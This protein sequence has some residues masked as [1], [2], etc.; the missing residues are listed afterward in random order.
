MATFN[1]RSFDNLWTDLT[2]SV[3]LDIE[4]ED[5]KKIFRNQL[6]HSTRLLADTVN[7]FSLQ[8]EARG[9]L[10]E[11]MIKNGFHEE[12]W[13]GMLD[14]ST[15]DQEAIKEITETLLHLLIKYKFASALPGWE[16][17]SGRDLFRDDVMFHLTIKNDNTMREIDSIWECMG[18][19]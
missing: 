12:L 7:Q 11:L 13:A 1:N 9:M 10:R 18:K 5:F 17:E 3:S 8:G 15:E 14:L 6:A 4:G 16:R 2:S 19:R